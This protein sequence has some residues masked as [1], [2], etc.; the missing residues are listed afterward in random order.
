VRPAAIAL[1]TAG[2][3]S[4]AACS[5]S[6]SGSTAAGSPSAPASPASGESAAPATSNSAFVAR[7]KQF[8][9]TATEQALT[10]PSVG[11]VPVSQ[12]VPW[13]QSMMPAPGKLVTGKQIRV[14]VVYGVPT[15]SA[16]YAAHLIQAIGPKLGW[17]VK[18]IEAAAQTPQATNA[19]VQQA[20]LDK[21]T[22]I[23]G[24]V[25]PAT[26]DGSALAAAKA[27]GIYTVL[28][29]QDTTT[30]KGYD[31]YVPD[32]E[33]IQKELLAA[34]A[35]AQSS[36]TAK[37]MVLNAPGFTD[38]NLPAAQNYLQQC[39]TCS[40]SPQQF[41]PN[42]FVDPV[43]LQSDVTSALSTASNLTYLMWPDGG[44]PLTPV[45]AAISGSSD[46]SAKLLIN[47]ATNDSIQLL[48]AGT[49]P[50]VVEAPLA[51]DALIAMDDVNRLVA[52]QQPLAENALRFP[53]SY[54]TTANGPAP[55][56]PAITET[57]LKQS[58][59]LT[60]FEKAWNVQLKS[61]ILSVSS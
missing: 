55:N 7:S 34:Y 26:W 24:A 9:Q 53:V 27:A 4:A 33:G 11:I 19:A 54:W 61:A 38:S 56:F 5:S 20:V 43:K 28:L 52:G 2:L 17:Q 32:A 13:K 59:W 41:N 6:S 45:T 49:I 50:V 42:D 57:E 15:G 3:L 18:V 22:A 14:D 51:L 58:D 12:L 37:T 35:V 39:S 16:P 46:S 36:G 44:L 21:P 29:H 8:L 47:D 40:T 1:V 48:K 23:I 31:A 60:P 30:G 25:I 10:G